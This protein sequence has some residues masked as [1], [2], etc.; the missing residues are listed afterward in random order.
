V[1]RERDK[2]KTEPP[3]EE[4]KGKRIAIWLFNPFYYVGGGRSLKIGLTFILF[5]GLAC[6]L[7]NSHCDGVLDFHMGSAAPEWFF[8]MEGI[9]AWLIMAALLFL[10][11][12]WISKSRIRALDVFGN[13]ALARSPIFITA[14][15]AIPPGSRR[16]AVKIVAFATGGSSNFDVSAL[17]LIAFVA[18]TGA[19]ILMTIWMILLMYR[20]FAVACNVRGGKAIGVFIGMLIVGEIISKVLFG[21]AAPHVLAGGDAGLDIERQGEMIGF[22]EIAPIAKTFVEGFLNK[23]FVK[24][25]GHFGNSMKRAMPEK[26]IEKAVDETL[27]KM[28]PFKRTTGYRTR[29]SMGYLA[30]YVRCEFEKKAADIKVVFDKQNLVCGLWLEDSKSA[31]KYEPFQP[32]E[33]SP[34]EP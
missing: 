21:V 6:A 17:D 9:V 18:L 31:S 19:A 3:A 25:T 4:S 8:V 28:G 10:A 32:E 24:V 22:G 13:Q 2:M 5:T 7:S 29:R 15:F 33:P 27:A 11:G 12:K 30:V 1:K 16:A 14:A 23:D 26:E 20:G 34:Q